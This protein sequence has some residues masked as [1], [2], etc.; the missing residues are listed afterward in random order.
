MKAQDVYEIDYSSVNIAGPQA[1][2]GRV[3]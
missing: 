1:A 2:Q 3:A